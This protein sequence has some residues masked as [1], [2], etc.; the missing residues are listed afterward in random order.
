MT[1]LRRTRYSNNGDLI[2]NADGLRLCDRD[3]QVGRSE[4]LGLAGWPV[5]FDGVNVC[6]G[7]EPEVQRN[8]ALGHVARFAVV[9]LGES[10]SAGLD[11]DSG[12]EAIAVGTR[13]DEF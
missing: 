7:V 3:G 9:V 12:T 6:R 4:A 13:A 10:A 1:S 11:F 5:H 2:C 8:G